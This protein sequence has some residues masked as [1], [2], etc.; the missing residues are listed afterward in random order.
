M[1]KA[2][3]FDFDGVI[4]TDF[5]G[6]STIAKNLSLSSGL[7]FELLRESFRN[8]YHYLTMEN[9]SYRDKWDEFCKTI[10]KELEYA[11]LEDALGTVPVNSEI[12]TIAQLLKEKYIV[13][14]ITDNSKERIDLIH[15]KLPVRDLFRPLIASGEV[16]LSKHGGGTGIFETA[17]QAAR[18]TAEESVFIDN[19]EKYLAEPGK[20][21][22][23]TYWHDDAKNDIVA[24]KRKLIGWGVDVEEE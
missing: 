9:G 19:Q 16:H 18:C 2:I 20:M 6:S 12:L 7:D 24:L 10:G 1:I 22:F 4:T 23:K 13:G 5:N 17:L 15:Q 14:M 3:F 8:I 21:G 11:Q